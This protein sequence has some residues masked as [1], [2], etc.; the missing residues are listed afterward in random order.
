MGPSSLSEEGF[1]KVW[2]QLDLRRFCGRPITP[3]DLCHPL[4]ECIG[5]PGEEGRETGY[6][7][8]GRYHGF[9]GSSEIE[10]PGADLV[11]AEGKVGCEGL[12]LLGFEPPVDL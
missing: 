7:F 6:G 2:I 8:P 5:L 12:G 9:A 11:E 10:K 4:T 1:A 3:L